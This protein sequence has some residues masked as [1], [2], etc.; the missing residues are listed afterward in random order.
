MRR[1][2]CGWVITG[3]SALANTLAWS[4][5]ST[6]LPSWRLVLRPS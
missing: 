5:R 4:I 2:V 3:L 6:W 1:I